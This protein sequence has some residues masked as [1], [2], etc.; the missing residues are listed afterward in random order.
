[1]SSRA[2]SILDDP[3]RAFVSC[4]ILRLEVLPKAVYHG[5]AE[6]RD[7]YETFFAGVTEW[8][9]SFPEILATAY[10]VACDH[11]LSAM[12][13]LH[14]AAAISLGADE[15]VT[16]EKSARPLHRVRSINIVS[17]RDSISG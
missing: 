16:A 17:I 14:V 10:R 1:V 7:F 3:Q 6:E 8:A 13:A 4:E 12:D 11:G 15:F 5:N 9:D 2:M